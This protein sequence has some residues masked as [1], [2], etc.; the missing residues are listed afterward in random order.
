[1]LRHCIG[2]SALLSLLQ[3]QLLLPSLCDCYRLSTLTEESVQKK[4]K[5][6]KVYF[7]LR[8]KKLKNANLDQVLNKSRSGTIAHKNKKRITAVTQSEVSFVLPSLVA[9]LSWQVD[10]I[11]SQTYILSNPP[12]HVYHKD[13]IY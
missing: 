12:F 3:P 6:E 4:K 10:S 8:H 5:A 9:P 13:A 1:L 11:V 7:Y 2:T